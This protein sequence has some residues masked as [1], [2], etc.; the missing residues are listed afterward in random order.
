MLRFLGA[1]LVILLFVTVSILPFW[2]YSQR[3]GYGPGLVGGGVLLG[4]IGL[5]HAAVLLSG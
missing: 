5:L 2:P 4:L 1:I 3:W